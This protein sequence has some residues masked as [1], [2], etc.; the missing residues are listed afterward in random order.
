MAKKGKVHRQVEFRLRDRSE[1]TGCHKCGAEEIVADVI[2]QDT[3]V[4]PP[5]EELRPLCDRCYDE[6]WRYLER[7]VDEGNAVADSPR[8][9]PQGSAENHAEIIITPIIDPNEIEMLDK[10]RA[11]K[12]APDGVK[13]RRQSSRGNRACRGSS[14]GRAAD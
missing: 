1:M 4:S 6:Y 11:E 8:T 9:K 10:I 2:I 3:R 14:G 7:L 12:R 13:T 5:T